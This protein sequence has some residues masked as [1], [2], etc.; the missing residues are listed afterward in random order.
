VEKK[1]FA[2][3]SDLHIGRSEETLRTA[4]WLRDALVDAEVDH[5]VATG[6]LT[7]RGR[8]SECDL[9]F[10]IFGS[11]IARRKMT[12]VPGNHDRLGD[13]CGRRIMGSSERVDV[14]DAEGL[15]LV[16]VDSTGP[17]NRFILAGHGSIC[18]RVIDQVDEALGRAPAGRLR[19]VV[20]HHHVLPLP[21]ETF[22]ERLATSLGWPFATEL[23]LGRRLIDRVRGRCDLIL[24]GHRHIP[25]ALR[26]WVEGRRPIG[27]YNAGSTTHLGRMRVFEHAAGE[28][29]ADPAWVTVAPTVEREE[30][31]H[32][33]DD[34][35]AVRGVRGGARPHRGA[36]RLAD[37]PRS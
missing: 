20:L 18:D 9:F 17:H 8:K 3:I 19:A 32:E 21:E 4:L 29:C 36:A 30:Q 7:H 2:H 35:G 12:V 1:R 24:H 15:W 37:S 11:L 14:V 10:D 28:L 33:L 5:V 27:I 23:E 16:R 6:D 31:S 34:L 13:D 22:P 25:R 26:L